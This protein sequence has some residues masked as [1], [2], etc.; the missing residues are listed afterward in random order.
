MVSFVKTMNFSVKEYIEFDEDA[1]IFAEKNYDL[2]QIFLCV[3]TG[4]NEGKKE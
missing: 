3:M 1:K 4:M 2:K